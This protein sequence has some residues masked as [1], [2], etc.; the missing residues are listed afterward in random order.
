MLIKPWRRGE[1]SCTDV[2]CGEES[3]GNSQINQFLEGGLEPLPTTPLNEAD[4]HEDAVGGRHFTFELEAETRF[5]Q[6]VHQQAGYAQR[7]RWR[8]WRR[9]SAVDRT[10]DFA[11]WVDGIWLNQSAALLGLH[12]V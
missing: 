11:G 7:S 3:D 12:E 9:G 8:L 2:C 1:V 10:Q 6:G 4:H 5:V